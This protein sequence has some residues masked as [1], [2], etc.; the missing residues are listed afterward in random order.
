MK[1][2]FASDSFKG[3]LSS[4]RIGTLLESAARKAFPDAE[5]IVLPI[6][7]GGEGTLAAIS[8]IKYGARIALHAHDGLMRPIDAEVFFDGDA[9]FVEAASTCGLALLEDGE[10][11][12]FATSSFGVG[13]CIGFALDRGCESVTVGLGG[14][15]T[16]D[17]GMGCLRAL[18]IRFFDCDEHELA[19]YGADLE[20]IA[21]IDESGL[22]CRARDVSFTVMNDVDNPL[23]GQNGATYV[24]GPQK[25]ATEGNL[26]RLEN[27]MKRFA[28]V[29]AI[30]HP[31]ADFATCGYGAAGGLGMALSVFLGAQLRPGIE[32]LLH[33]LDF[34]TVAKGADLVVTGE[35]KLDGQSLQ[36]KAVSGIV[37][38]AKRIGV[39]VAAL[40]G[41]VALNEHE[42]HDVGISRAIDISQGQ[43]LDYA[44]AHAEQNYLQAARRLFAAL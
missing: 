43:A 12:P 37:A 44:L 27:G 11:N 5:C 30:N 10:R 16:N 14:S 42:L 19:G 35:G 29:I 40:C 25:G 34:D 17:G 26:A 8:S 1:F 23:L 15:C 6:A 41:S 39:P 32:E 21:R 20:R 13:E 18:G 9:A 22:H 2:V 24:F 33:W 36:G 38:H 28:D 3:T 4:A 7:D 31:N